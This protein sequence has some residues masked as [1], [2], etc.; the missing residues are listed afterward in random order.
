MNIKRHLTF[1]ALFCLALA[2]QA[3]KLTS[4]NGNLVM[5]FSLNQAG[6]PTYDLYF[7]GKAVIKPSTN[8]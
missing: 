4:P 2:V 6:A 8:R 5:N 3:Q 7:K 1:A